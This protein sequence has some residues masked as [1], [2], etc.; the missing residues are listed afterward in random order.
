M[1]RMSRNNLY[2]WL[3][4]SAILMALGAGGIIFQANAAACTEDASHAGNSAGTAAVCVNTAAGLSFDRSRLD[5]ES[6]PRRVQWH[7]QKPHSDAKRFSSRIK[8][9]LGR[10][11]ATRRQQF[12]R[13]QA[14]MERQRGDIRRSKARS[15]ARQFAAARRRAAHHALKHRHHPQ[16]KRLGNRMGAPPN[17]G[18]N[19][20]HALHWRSHSRHGAHTGK[21]PPSD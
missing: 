8:R 16:L 12:R 1:Y 9:H 3:L 19:V 17:D 4:A 7:K 20:R 21:Q 10:K 11:F 18:S 2:R 5:S 14:Q 13:H 6:A 15:K